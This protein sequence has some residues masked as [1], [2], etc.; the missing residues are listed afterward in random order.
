MALSDHLRELRAR[1]LKVG[2]IL[3]IGLIVALMFFDQLFDF[4]KGPYQQAQ[5]A[6]GKDRTLP[7]T[8]GAGGGLLL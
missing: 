5:D 8:S 1:L 4:V 3:V 6:L 7:T 2:L